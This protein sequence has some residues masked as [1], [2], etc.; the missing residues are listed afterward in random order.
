M[1][2]VEDSI[3]HHLSRTPYLPL[4]PI[5]RGGM[6]TV[7]R[8]ARRS[9]GRA[10]ALKIPRADR[11]ISG[12]LALRLKREARALR[13]VRTPRV[14]GLVDAGILDDGRPYLVMD[15]LAGPDL[16]TYVRRQGLPTLGKAL[17]WVADALDG[18]DALHEK[19]VVHRD[20]KLANLVLDA[21][22]RV[23]VIDLSASKIPEDGLLRTREGFVMGTPR[24]MAPEQHTEGH[25]DVRTDIYGAGLALYELLTGRGPFD[26][27]AHKKDLLGFAHCLRAPVPPSLVRA[28]RLPRAVDAVVLK[29]LEKDPD[30]R[31]Q[32]ASDM[33]IAL[34]RLAT[35]L[36]FLSETNAASVACELV[37]NLPT[38]CLQTG[39]VWTTEV[40]PY[41]RSTA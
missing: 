33:A 18:L 7:T 34:R 20:V 31:Y 37:D 21:E 11:G 32:R 9:D 5:G 36:G 8:V 17:T 23:V 24:H 26:D 28:S 41:Q 25:A 16:H 19:G 27:V 13:S 14:V 30:K 15:G 38:L 4:A 35:S 1:I 3:G 29:A 2:A 22:E 40:E 12:E 10:F 39:D 6:G